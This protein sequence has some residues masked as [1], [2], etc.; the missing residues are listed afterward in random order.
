MSA[1]SNL[2]RQAIMAQHYWNPRDLHGHAEASVWW[3]RWSKAARPGCYVATIHCYELGV[4]QNHQMVV[5]D[6]GTLKRVD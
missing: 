5:D 4:C 2:E 6:F 1:L 3:L